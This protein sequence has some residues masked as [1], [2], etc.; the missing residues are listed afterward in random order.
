LARKWLDATEKQYCATALGFGLVAAQ[1]RD[2]RAQLL[3][4]AQDTL[5]F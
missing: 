2:D 5:V 4:E 3:D 1:N